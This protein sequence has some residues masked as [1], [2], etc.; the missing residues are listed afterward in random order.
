MQGVEETTMAT[1]VRG[2]YR[3]GK[4]ELSE[5]PNDVR[6]EARV[7][8]TFVDS[9]QKSTGIDLRSRGIDEAEAARMRASLAAFAEEWD[10]PEMDIYDD[11][12]A[13]KAANG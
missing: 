2:V 4:V 5:V 11:Y 10:S 8:V 13:A 3:E 6:E 9:G 12:D 1:T 7:I